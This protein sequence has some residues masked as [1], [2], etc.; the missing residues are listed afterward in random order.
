MDFPSE[1]ILFTSPIK[2]STFLFRDTVFKVLRNTIDYL[3]IL[4]LIGRFEPRFFG[5]IIPYRLRIRTLI[6]GS[7]SAVVPS[8]QGSVHRFIFLLSFIYFIFLFLRKYLKT[9][10]HTHTLAFFTC[11]WLILLSRLII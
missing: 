2:R 9:L 7:I 5:Y 11:T 6:F 3:L 8:R 10:R 1:L 4:V